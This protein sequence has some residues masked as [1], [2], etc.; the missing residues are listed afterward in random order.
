MDEVIDGG[1]K[2][3][4]EWVSNACSVVPLSPFLWTEK[5][6]CQTTIT[7]MGDSHIRNLFTATVHGLRGVDAFVEGHS[8]DAKAGGVVRSY[9]WRWQDGVATDQA[10]MH[11]NTNRNAPAP[12][13]DCRCDEVQRCLR[14]AF[15]WA[16]T[17]AEQLAKMAWAQEWQSDLVVVEPGNSYESRVPLSSAWTAALDELLQRNPKTHLSLLHFS[18]GNQPAERPA[19]LAAWVNKSAAASRMS[20]LPQSAIMQGDNMQSRKTWHF[21]CGLEKVQAYNDGINA[22]EPCWDITDTAQIRAIVTVH[23]NA[24]LNDSE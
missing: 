23:F 22:V 5:A 9:E 1:L 18:W 15:V 6:K 7:M 14:I 3:D 2:E 13:E 17:F 11:V 16:P 20:Y 4:G 12:F 24:F 21:A 8:S 10:L 19:V